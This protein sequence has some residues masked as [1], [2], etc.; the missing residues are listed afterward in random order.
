MNQN[1]YNSNWK[2]L[3]GFRNMQEKLEKIDVPIPNSSSN[4]GWKKSDDLEGF[5]RKYT[6]T[7]PNLSIQTKQIQSRV[8]YIIEFQFPCPRFPGTRT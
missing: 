3:L 4:M 1:N 6:Y 5:H 2:K 7:P 8:I